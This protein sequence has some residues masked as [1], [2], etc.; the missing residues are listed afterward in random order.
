MTITSSISILSAARLIKALVYSDFD[1][2]A[3]WFLHENLRLI[4]HSKKN[5]KMVF[6]ERRNVNNYPVS[7][8]V[9]NSIAGTFYWRGK[10]II[11]TVQKQS[12]QTLKFSCHVYFY[13]W[14]LNMLVTGADLAQVRVRLAGYP[15]V[16]ISADLSAP[17]ISGGYPFFYVL[18]FIPYYTW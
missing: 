3:L 13:R 15:F 12:A 9:F 14:V 8:F 16:R 4:V 2:T 1:F 6:V 10:K 7:L 5:E 18:I 11:D 17:R